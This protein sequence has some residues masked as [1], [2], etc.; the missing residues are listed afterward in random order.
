LADFFGGQGPKLMD[1]A[2]PGVELRVTGQTLFDA[3]HP[4]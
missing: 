2:D 3:W 1:E 4:D